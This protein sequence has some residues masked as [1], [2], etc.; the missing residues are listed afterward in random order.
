[1]LLSYFLKSS[2]ETEFHDR[3]GF[4]RVIKMSMYEVVSKA[5]AVLQ[6][7]SSQ[8]GCPQNGRSQNGRESTNHRIWWDRR[9][10]FIGDLFYG[11]FGKRPFWHVTVASSIAK[12]P[13]PIQSTCKAR[14]T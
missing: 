4:M 7:V 3:L 14:L 11:P 1:M 5:A 13:G 6:A 2:E 8:K 10:F 12:P 9:I